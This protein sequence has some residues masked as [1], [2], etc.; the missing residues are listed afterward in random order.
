MA[1]VAFDV[2]IAK[3]VPDGPDILAHHPG[4]ACAAI[5]REGDA[6]A[7]ILFDPSESPELFEP[8]TKALTRDG[9]LRILAALEEAVGRGDTLVTWNGAGFDFRL[10]ADETGR[11]ADCARLALASV[12]MMFQV[13]CERGHPLSLD[14]ALK[15]AALPPKM[16][17]VTLR[18]GEAVH[19][20]GAEAPQ[21]LAGGRVRG[22]GG[23]LRRRRGADRRPRS[24]VPE[25]PPARLGQPERPAQPGLPA[26]RLAHGGAVPRAPVAGHELD[27]Q[28]DEPRRRPCV[29]EAAP[30]AGSR[31]SGCGSCP[32]RFHLSSGDLRL[33]SLRADGKRLGHPQPVKLPSSLGYK[34]SGIGFR[35]RASAARSGPEAGPASC[36]RRSCRAPAR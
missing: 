29:D 7:S 34:C 16:T 6:R 28:A 26:N 22:G 19:I 14:A 24:R 33:S 18:S 10:L 35:I 36:G 25:E 3:P 13:L 23:L 11:H 12:D 30:I 17:E 15:G 2:E 32:S 5:A 21:D 9:S 1:F 8:A 20:T 4:I 31:P 27:D